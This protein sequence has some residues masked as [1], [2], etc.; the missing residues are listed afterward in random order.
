[1]AEWENHEFTSCHG[2]TKM[3]T[4]DEKDQNLAKKSSITKDINNLWYSQV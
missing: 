4:I 2:H 1:M 3:L